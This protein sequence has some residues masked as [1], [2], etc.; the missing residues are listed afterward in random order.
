MFNLYEAISSIYKEFNLSNS[1]VH[2][3]RDQAILFDVVDHDLFG[4]RGTDTSALRSWFW[5]CFRYR[6]TFVR[7]LVGGVLV[8]VP[9]KFQ[10]SLEVFVVH[11]VR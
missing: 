3:H 6:L 7:F 10:K 11:T 5:F 2:I 8:C 4:Q 1:L 9:I